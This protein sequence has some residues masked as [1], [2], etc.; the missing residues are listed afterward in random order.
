MGGLAR[1]HVAL[2]VLEP[3]DAAWLVGASSDADVVEFTDIPSAWSQAD[4]E[5]W[6][7]RRLERQASTWRACFV[8]RSDG[9]RAG[10]VNLRISWGLLTGQLGF[11]LLEPFRGRGVITTSCALVRDW[12]FDGLAIARLEIA[13]RPDNPDSIRVAERLGAAREGLLRSSDVVK[14]VRHDQWLYALLPSDPRT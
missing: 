10:Y 6:I 4:A 1:G 12:A 8:V 2:R 14:G 13:M 11:W 5:A 9:A 7:A 3:S